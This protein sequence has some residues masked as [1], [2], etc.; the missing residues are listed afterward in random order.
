MTVYA[1]KPFF[2]SLIESYT[3]LWTLELRGKDSAPKTFRVFI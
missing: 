2:C 1:A 3:H